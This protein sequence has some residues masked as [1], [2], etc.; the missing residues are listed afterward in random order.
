[1]S[2]THVRVVVGAEHGFGH[3]FLLE[4]GLGGGGRGDEAGE[5]I[6]GFFGPVLADFLLDG[7]VTDGIVM[8][9]MGLHTGFFKPWNFRGIVKCDMCP[10]HSLGL[11]SQ[12]ISNIHL[13]TWMAAEDGNAKSEDR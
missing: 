5:V 7:L 1:M 10:N 8:V 4:K 2:L 11:G 3:P 12:P 9:K 13:G 6:E